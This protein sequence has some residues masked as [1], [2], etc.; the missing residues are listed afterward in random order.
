MKKR[1]IAILLSLSVFFLSF[2]FG[3]RRASAAATGSIVALATIGTFAFS[4]LSL[5]TTGEAEKISQEVQHWIEYEL[6]PAG[7]TWKDLY[8]DNLD[9]STPGVIAYNQIL[10]TV[11]DW[12]GNGKLEV[13]DGQIK[14]TYNQYMELYGQVV[15]VS[16]KPDLSFECGYDYYFLTPFRSSF[17]PVSIPQISVYFT[18][19]KNKGG[20][21]VIP[22]FYSDEVMYFS[23]CYFNMKSYPYGGFNFAVCQLRSDLNVD[24]FG[25]FTTGS[26]YKTFDEAI[27]EF[28]PIIYLTSHSGAMDFIM[29]GSKFH[30]EKSFDYMFKFDGSSVTSIPKSEFSDDGLTAGYVA[31]VGDVGAFMKSIRGYTPNLVPPANLD[32]LSNVLPTEYNPSLSF[33][34]DPDLTRLLPNQVIVEDVPGVADLPLSE[35]QAEIKTEI[36]V[37]SIICTKFPF[38]IPYDFMRFLG[39]LCSDPVAPVF[40]IPIS[41]SPDNLEQ[42]KGN[43]TVGEY[44]NA[45]DP[46]FEIDEEI[47]IDLSVIPLVQPL[48]YTCFIVGFVFLLLHI[49]PKMIQH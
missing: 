37:S 30:Y 36:E 18:D 41:T 29:T 12:F 34:V 42:W 22:V 13:V 31:T 8:F 5:I 11:Q 6:K 46:M 39:M 1:I 44:L 49:T 25:S 10:K 40:R 45:D 32:N 3:T 26:L 38:C 33:P 27:S 9:T 21:S 7:E 2:S 47:V 19:T 23:S 14:L 17:S 28:Q 4:V 20:Q 48:C 16:S 24:Y 15:S 35:Y 43:Q